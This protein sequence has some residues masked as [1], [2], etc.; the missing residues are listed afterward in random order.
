Q[1]TE[2]TGN[3]PTPAFPAPSEKDRQEV[4]HHF[5]LWSEV[6]LI[7]NHQFTPGRRKVRPME[8]NRSI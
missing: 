3:A 7:E 4:C 5:P 8:L 6:C 1:D 2:Q